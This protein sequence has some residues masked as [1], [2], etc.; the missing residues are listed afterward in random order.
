MKSV[1]IG[2]G[3]SYTALAK[4]RE[5]RNRLIV[6]HDQ[7]PGVVPQVQAMLP[8]A[9]GLNRPDL[10]PGMAAAF[11][12]TKIPPA[13]GQGAFRTGISSGVGGGFFKGWVQSG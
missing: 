11:S 1:R 9:A 6:I 13:S 5:V 8:A 12:V 10:R 2:T 4:A 3:G 7:K